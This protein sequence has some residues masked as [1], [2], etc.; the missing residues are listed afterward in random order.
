MKNLSTVRLST[1]RLAR[2][3]PQVGSGALSPR[4]CLG[5]SRQ[6]ILLIVIIKLILNQHFETV[7][8]VEE[9]R[10]GFAIPVVD[11]ERRFATHNCYC[12]VSTASNLISV[13]P[14]TQTIDPKAMQF[15]E[16]H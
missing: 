3:F 8:V 5:L 12:H 13:D 1:V 4:G 11:D 16:S 2:K 15:P 14:L 7:H 6:S 9:P 10:Y